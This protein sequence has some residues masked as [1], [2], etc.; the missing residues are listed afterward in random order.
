[1]KSVWYYHTAEV[2]II[3]PTVVIALA[4]S[5]DGNCV[6]AKPMTKHGGN[7]NWPRNIIK[8]EVL[9]SLAHGYI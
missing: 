9:G 6:S 4:G 3:P 1:M 2:V 7:Q 5:S 8:L